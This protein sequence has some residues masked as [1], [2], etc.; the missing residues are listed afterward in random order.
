MG[1]AAGDVNHDGSSDIVTSYSDGVAAVILGSRSGFIW[2]GSASAEPLMTARPALHDLNLDGHLDILLNGGA[3]LR[4]TGDGT[5][6]APEL[7]AFSSYQHS[8]VDINGDA[9]PDIVATPRDGGIGVLL[10]VR[11]DVNTNPVVDAA[12]RTFAYQAQYDVEGTYVRMPGR[13]VDMHALSYEWRDEEGTVIATEDWAYLPRRDPGTYEYKVTVRDGRGG[14]DSNTLSVTV[15]PLKEIVLHAAAGQGESW[16]RVDDATAAGG[17]RRYDPNM[18]APKVTRPLANPPRYLT[19]PLIADP[20]QTYKLWVRL[21]ADG[22]SYANDSIW[23]QLT[24]AIDQAGRRYEPGTTSGL[25]V[26]LEECGGCGISGWGWE[27]DGWGA[28]NRN[29]VMLRFPT[30]GRHTIRIQTR[31]DGVSIDQVVLS[32]EKYLTTRPGAAK[33]DAT[34]LPHTFWEF[35]D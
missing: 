2:A 18:R 4:G 29:G 33:N 9:L 32:A 14:E 30:A 19:I 22:N 34:I 24:G 8:A 12:T 26:N 28:P 16:L 15:T 27:D 7:F 6:A 13:D 1:A 5:F 25:E 20:T 17:Q 10:N 3:L 35:D 31:E 11:S 21:K 23:L